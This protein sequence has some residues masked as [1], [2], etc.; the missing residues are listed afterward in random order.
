MYKCKYCGKKYKNPKSI[1]SHTKWCKKNPNREIPFENIDQEK[2]LKALADSN[3][4]PEHIRRRM[5]GF[6]KSYEAGNFTIGGCSNDT[7][8]ESKRRKKIAD[9]INKRYESGWA[10]KAGRCKKIQ[11]EST[12]A[13]SVSL[14]GN[15]ELKVAQYLDEQNIN[16]IRNTKR[17]P[18]IHNGK[19]RK[20]TPDFYLTDD[21][22]YVEVKGYETELDKCK[23]GQFPHS[24]LVW[25]KYDLELMGIL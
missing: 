24:L 13:G 23:W 21:D 10:P 1:G 14:D 11:Y 4:N 2:R 22:V 25:K 19:N 6:K 17:F 7:E 9:S 5:A 18:Y 8:I 12:I 20:Y 3:R 16:W 15:W